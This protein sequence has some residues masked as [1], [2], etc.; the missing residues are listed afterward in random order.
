MYYIVCTL[1]NLPFLFFFFLMIRRPP[2]STLFP[3]TTLFRSKRLSRMISEYL[4]IAQL[5]SGARALRLAPVRIASLV[6]RVLLLLDPVAAQ[7]HIKIVRRLSP[8]L[9]GL[10]AD[11][12]LIAQALTNLIANAIKYSPMQTE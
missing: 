4:D 7:R 8:N 10:L 3:Y 5:E 6:E 9:P 1:C 11:A 12:D 2:R